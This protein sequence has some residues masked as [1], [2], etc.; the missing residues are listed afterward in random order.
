MDNSKD[1]MPQLLSQP[2]FIRISYLIGKSITERKWHGQQVR[3]EWWQKWPMSRH[4]DHEVTHLVKG[5]N[6]K[7]DFNIRMIVH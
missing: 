3:R 5:T 2:L 1:H 6:Y 7:R 4:E